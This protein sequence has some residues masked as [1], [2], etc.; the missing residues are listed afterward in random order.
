M[1][2]PFS[3]RDFFKGTLLGAGAVALGAAAQT[4]APKIQGFDETNAG[5]LS[6]RPWRPVSDR[7][8]KV[9]IAGYGVC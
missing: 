4:A 5:K 9:G 3:R 7:K 2:H 8:I 1:T 6:D